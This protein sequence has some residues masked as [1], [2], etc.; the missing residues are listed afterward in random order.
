MTGLIKISVL[1]IDIHSDNETYFR[2]D[3]SNNNCS[4]FLQFYGYDDSFH[5]FGQ[6]LINFP[7]TIN[8]TPIFEI[9]KD[10]IKW[11]YYLNIKVLCYDASGHSAIKIK[12]INNG[13][14][15]SGYQSEFTIVAEA[16]SIN[17]LGQLLT[18]WNPLKTKEVVWNSIKS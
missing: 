4:T 9:G 1:S 12:A 16:A 3:I 2:I 10:D 15:I 11:A 14:I 13:D 18:N 5:E 7:Q 6:S 8:D 17:Q